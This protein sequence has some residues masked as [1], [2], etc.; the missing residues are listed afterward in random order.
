ML[1]GLF[2]LVI[3]QITW[4]S[5]NMSN[6]YSSITFYVV[7]VIWLIFFNLYCMF[8]VKALHV[9]SH[10]LIRCE[11]WLWIYRFGYLTLQ[12]SMLSRVLGPCDYNDCGREGIVG[13]ERDLRSGK[14]R[15]DVSRRVKR[16][17]LSESS[18]F[19]SPTRKVLGRSQ[20]INWAWEMISWYM[21]LNGTS[22]YI[23]MTPS[24]R[25]KSHK[26]FMQ[27]YVLYSFGVLL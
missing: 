15:D 1:N 11:K 3:S 18:I 7:C 6:I 14:I 5:A 21:A 27:D 9:I 23:P 16:K 4:F 2:V 25:S 22:Y 17:R 19:G 13:V 12:L 26:Y 24:G 20:C 10:C 8:N